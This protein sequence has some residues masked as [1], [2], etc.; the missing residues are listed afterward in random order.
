[1]ALHSIIGNHLVK[2]TFCW[3]ISAVNKENKSLPDNFP[4]F[5]LSERFPGCSLN[6]MRSVAFLDKVSRTRC[7]CFVIDFPIINFYVLLQLSYLVP[8]PVFSWLSSR[9]I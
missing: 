7:F 6:G 2:I 9:S 8:V 1:M 3:K 4:S 5:V